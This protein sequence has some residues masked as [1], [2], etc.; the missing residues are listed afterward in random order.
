MHAICEWCVTS[1]V[2][3]TVLACL[4]CGASC[5]A[6]RPLPAPSPPAPPGLE[7]SRTPPRAARRG[8]SSRRHRIERVVER[9]KRAAAAGRR[10][11]GRRT[12]RA[13]GWE[14][15]RPSPTCCPRSPPAACRGCA[16]SR[17]PPP[18]RRPRGRSA[19]R[20]S[21][22]TSSATLDIAIDGAD[23]IDPRGWLIKGG[24]AAHTREKIVAAAARRFVVI[25][26]AEKAVPALTPPVPVEILRFGAH[27]TLARDRPR[28]AARRARS[29]RTA[30]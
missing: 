20:S 26:S 7:P 24:G 17:P 28:A 14:R 29:A 8:L 16:A 19:W 13:S 25:A 5:A 18:P 30:T 3:M 6:R 11:A 1:A 10:G 4:A 12:A 21:S 23:Q 2:I 22:S 9:H 27:T 15:D